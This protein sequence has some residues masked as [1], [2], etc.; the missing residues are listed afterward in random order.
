[1]KLLDPAD[2]HRELGTL[3]DRLGPIQALAFSTD[4][5]TLATAGVPARGC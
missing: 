4:G 3:V 5:R 1:M 2:E